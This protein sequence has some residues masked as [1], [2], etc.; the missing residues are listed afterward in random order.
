M[1]KRFYSVIQKEIVKE[2]FAVTD[3]A[4]VTTTVLFRSENNGNDFH[5]SERP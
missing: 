1:H 3:V 5:A 4:A 2:L